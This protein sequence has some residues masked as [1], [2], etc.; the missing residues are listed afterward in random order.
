MLPHFPRRGNG[1]LTV[2][3]GYD[4]LTILCHDRGMP[5]NNPGGFMAFKKPD[6]TEVKASETTAVAEPEAASETP[7]AEAQGFER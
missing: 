5:M 3:I 6:Q 1:S 7:Q 2:S 4:L